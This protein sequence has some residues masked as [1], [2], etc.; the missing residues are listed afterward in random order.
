MRNTTNVNVQVIGIMLA[1]I[2]LCV[3]ATGA[4][5]VNDYIIEKYHYSN[6]SEMPIQQALKLIQEHG[7]NSQQIITY[8]SND[9]VYVKYDFKSSSPTEYG[10]MGGTKPMD[11]I[12]GILPFMAGILMAMASIKAVKGMANDKNR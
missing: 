10:L 11:F 8:N 2:T 4:V 9:S 7:E 12:W 6:V 5:S 3:F 1:F